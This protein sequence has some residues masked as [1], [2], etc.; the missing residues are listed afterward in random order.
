MI[1]SDP[2]R[3]F[4]TTNHISYTEIC[5]KTRI[6]RSPL[7]RRKTTPSSPAPRLALGASGDSCG[8]PPRH[9]FDVWWRAYPIST[10]PCR[11]PASIDQ[12]ALPIIWFQAAAGK[13]WR[14][15]GNGDLFRGDTANKTH[16]DMDNERLPADSV[17][18]FMIDVTVS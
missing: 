1:C 2:L 8:T 3:P 5:L 12:S 18:I 13:A 15:T 9:A 6:D 16:W 10:M 11:W 7:K 14:V 17:Y 4:P